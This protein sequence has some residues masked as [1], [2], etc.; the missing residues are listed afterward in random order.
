MTPHYLNDTYAVTSQLSVKDIAEAARQGFRGIICAR[1]DGEEAGQPDIETLE[2]AAMAA[3][4][5]FEAVPVKSGSLPNQTD[6]DRTKVMLKG[7][8]GPGLGYCRTGNRAAQL[9]AVAMAG[10]LCADQ[11]RLEGPKA[12]FNFSP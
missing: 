4:V 1:P 3:G 6:I 2:K 11:S 5:T 7:V 10:T 9:W 8:N 12:G